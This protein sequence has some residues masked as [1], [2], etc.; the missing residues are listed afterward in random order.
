MKIGIP[1]ERREHEAR[2]AAS[3]DTVKKY[4]GLGFEVV[5]EAG[6]GAGASIP[7][8]A[9]KEAGAEIA[10]DEAYRLGALEAVVPREELHATARGLADK[11]AAKSPVALRLAKESLNGIELL[12]PKQS[13]RFEQGFTLELYRAGDSQ[14]AREAFVE[15]REAKFSD[16]S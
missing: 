13:Y 11:I 1:A 14:E 15:K 12:D 4:V 3:P 7:D 8:D 2:V 16:R 5:V 9:F 10:A 6:A